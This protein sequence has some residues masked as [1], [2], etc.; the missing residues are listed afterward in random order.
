M[1]RDAPS[2]PSCLGKLPIVGLGAKT[3]HSQ[4]L[5]TTFCTAQTASLLAEDNFVVTE[6]LA[7]AG[8]GGCSSP[9]SRIG[10]VLPITSSRTCPELPIAIAC[11]PP[12]RCSINMAMRPTRRHHWGICYQQWSAPF[13]WQRCST[14][15]R[16]PGRQDLSNLGDVITARATKPAFSFAARNLCQPGWCGR[17]GG[18]SRW[19]LLEIFAM[20]ARPTAFVSSMATARQT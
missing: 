20:R 16:S 9:A 14:Q 11:S 10:A 7:E 15:K 12:S 19:R 1:A 5:R 6:A 17:G 2:L 8:R 18:Q 3:T 4:K 13:A